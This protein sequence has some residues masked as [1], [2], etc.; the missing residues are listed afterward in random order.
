[1]FI[2]VTGYTLCLQTDNRYYFVT[3]ENL[4]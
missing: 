4:K 2:K 1:M 3:K